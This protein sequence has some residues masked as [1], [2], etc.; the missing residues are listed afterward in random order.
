MSSDM[1]SIQSL[2]PWM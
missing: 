1:A 2:E